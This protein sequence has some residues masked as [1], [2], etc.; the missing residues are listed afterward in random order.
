MC[1]NFP[2]YSA[3]IKTR[4]V[5]PD[6][7]GGVAILIK[8]GIRHSLITDLDDSMEL[9]GVKIELKEVC[10]DF[11]SLYSPP[12]QIIS[13]DFFKNLEVNKI[14]FIIVGDL[15][16]KTQSI[17]C[18]SQDQ[19]GHVLDLVLTDTSF[20]IHNNEIPTYYQ[21]RSNIRLSVQKSQ[22]SEILDLAIS[23]SNISNRIRN[24]EV[25]TKHNMTS[26]H[27]PIAFN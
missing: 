14:D 13:Y 16:S 1:L 25:L 23:S 18:K 12:G 26:D 4:I 7:G 21:F 11:F 6:Q 22:Y 3:Y 20:V 15:N 27:C 19:S 17:G 2:G 10:F 5:N 9:V 8:D 24:F